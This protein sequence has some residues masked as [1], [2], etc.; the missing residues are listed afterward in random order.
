MISKAGKYD[1]L[2]Q[3]LQSTSGSRIHASFLQLERLLGDKLP[4][5]AR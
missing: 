4:A 2:S 3:F 1:P 5:S